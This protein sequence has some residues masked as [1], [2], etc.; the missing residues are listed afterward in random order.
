M[1]FWKKILSFFKSKGSG[2]VQPSIP[3]PSTQPHKLKTS[4]IVAICVGHSRSG[5]NGAVSTDGVSEWVY[6]NKVANHLKLSLQA[7]GISC[8]V[9]NK[10]EGGS[11]GS[12]M[13]WLVRELK[14][15]KATVAIE[16][17]FNAATPKAHGYEYLHFSTSSKSKLLA[18]ELL[19]AHTSA[20]KYQT[21][22]GVK[23]KK[24]GARGSGFLSRTHCPAVIV[25][26]F[27]GSNVAEWKNWKNS[28]K[29]LAAIYHKGIVNYI[30]R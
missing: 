2:R 3:R 5:D 30:K 29:D 6:N 21:S 23:P 24:K 18:D 10:Y 16:L 22:R 15:R 27:F 4:E 8:F 12:A 19:K 13:S 17:H 7:Q 1:K 28:Q 14:S 20:R 25:E 9:L 11:Y 26:P